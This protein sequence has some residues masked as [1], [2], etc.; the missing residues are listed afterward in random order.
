MLQQIQGSMELN[1]QGSM[2]LNFDRVTKRLDNLEDRMSGIE[3]K[4][5]RFEW[6]HATP[7]SSASSSSPPERGRNRRSPPELQHEIRRI[8]A[9][10]NE[11]NQLNLDERIDSDQNKMVTNKIT[12][13]LGST[14]FTKRQIKGYELYQL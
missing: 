8:H 10:F 14:K 11:E 5:T 12:Q 13:E 9:A 2:E 7:P 1:F 6:L 3:E 4:H